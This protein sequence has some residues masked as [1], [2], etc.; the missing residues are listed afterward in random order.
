MVFVE[1]RQYSRTK[2]EWPASI[3][4]S[5]GSIE[6]TV[7]NISLGGAFIR[8]AELPYMD[9]TLDLSIEIPEH[10]YALFTMA[11]PVRFDVDESESTSVFYGLGV[12]LKDIP[13]DDVEFLSTTAL[14]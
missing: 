3:S 1:K 5:Q 2:V 9:E 10:H 4:T 14:R 12:R 7:K 11:E 8:L 13:E 6:G